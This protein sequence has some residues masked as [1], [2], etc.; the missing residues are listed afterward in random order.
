MVFPKQ[1][2]SP[3]CHLRHLGKMDGGARGGNGETVIFQSILMLGFM[4]TSLKVQE[5]NKNVPAPGTRGDN[6][7]QFLEKM[8]R[9]FYLQ[10]SLKA[11]FRET[12]IQM[13]TLNLI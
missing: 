11:G 3:F 10:A 8:S 5:A 2:M 12:Y 1:G 7:T 4:M 9:A 6:L 13:V